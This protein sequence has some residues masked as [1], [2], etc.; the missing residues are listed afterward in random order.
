[1]SGIADLIVAGKDLG[2]FQFYLPFIIL[3]A[4]IYGLLTKSKVFGEKAR[5]LNA[6]IA[7]AFAF[8][9]MEY[10]LAAP[11]ETFFAQFAGTTMAILIGIIGFLM[12]TY[13]L[14][15]VVGGEMPDAKK[16]AKYVVL[17]GIILAIGA[18]LASGGAAIFPG[19]SIGSP[20]GGI[21][22]GIPGISALTMSDIAIIAL[23]VLTLALVIWLIRGEKDVK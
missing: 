22:G 17:I 19:I 3:F 13:M 10:A 8:F 20:T 7:L 12:V 14:L 23:I 21:T 2:V 4:I 6:I 18:Y 11:L 15:A 1:M 9:I 5:G 16:Y